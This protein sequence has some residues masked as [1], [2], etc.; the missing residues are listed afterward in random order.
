LEK[1][2]KL[3][4]LVKKYGSKAQKE[5]FKKN[6]NLSGK[7][8]AILKKSVLQVWES[9]ELIE[10]R[11]SKRIF[12]CSGKR[13]K[14]AEPPD[15]RSNNGQGQLKGEFELNSLVVNYLIEKK[16][17]V[18]PMAATKWITELGVVDPKLFGAVYGDRSFHLE[19]LQ[20]QFSNIIKDY[21]QA[22]NEAEMLEE[23]LTKQLEHIKSSLVSVFSKLEKAKV[24]I[25]QIEK[26]GCTNQNTYRK[27]NRNEVKMI[28]DI[29]RTLLNTYGLKNGDLYKK[30]SK[31]VKDYKRS[32]DE[33]L[34][35]QLG[36]KYYYDAHFC[37]LQEG[38]LGVLDYLS[39][40]EE[41]DELDFAYTLTEENAFIMSQIYKDIQ[42][43]RSLELAQNREMNIFNKSDSERI[44]LLKIMKQYAQMWELLLRYFKCNSCLKSKP[45]VVEEVA[46]TKIEI[47]GVELEISNELKKT[48]PIAQFQAIRWIAEM[49]KH[50]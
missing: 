39:R 9:C 31:S 41:K 1:R 43:M 23:F 6:G 14:K 13:S 10:G 5:S 19:R 27:L 4:E 47:D 44:Q 2:F 12:S 7:E 50:Q 20:E 32:L 33:E 30:N 34:Q 16:N 22:G 36:L 45:N 40:L 37:V 8:F 35:G 18:V 17:K 28:A 29:K 48:N 49:D 46:T 21:K 11:G 24:I 3:A 15:N 26:W 42:S 25:H 38:D